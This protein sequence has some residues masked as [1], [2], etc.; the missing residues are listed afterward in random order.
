MNTR[1][2][3]HFL[4]NSRLRWGIS[5]CVVTGIYLSL[6]LSAM[7]W[8]TTPVPIQTQA[9]TTIMLYLPP[10]SEKS[11]SLLT[12]SST[13]PKVVPPIDI[14]KSESVKLPPK[15]VKTDPQKNQLLNPSAKLPEKEV[16]SALAPKAITAEQ[17]SSSIKNTDIKQTNTLADKPTTSLIKIN[18]TGKLSAPAASDTHAVATWQSDLL[19]H[20]E[21][22]KRYPRQA[23]RRGFEAV[24][25]VRV[26]IDKKG[27]VIQHQ[28]SQASQYRSLNREVMALITRAQPL[29]APPQL[30]GDTISFVLPV[31]FS[32]K[33]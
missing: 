1:I 27:R 8:Q 33:Q 30:H 24:I 21:R 29:P 3:N 15:I 32:L 23:R 11:N 10:S 2:H 14:K 5:F 7:N 6:I 4:Y 19:A 20:I 18:T 31:T 22:Y 28:L 9:I 26:V 17:N 16:T 13:P 12:I 25:H